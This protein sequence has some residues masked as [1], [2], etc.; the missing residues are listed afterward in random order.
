MIEKNCKKDL[1]RNRTAIRLF[2]AVFSALI[3]VSARAG[4][5]AGRDAAQFSD[6]P[7]EHWHMMR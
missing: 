6:V 3:L 2:A 4:A 5:Y 7:K 1:E